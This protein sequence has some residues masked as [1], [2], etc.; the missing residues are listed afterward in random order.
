MKA[1]KEEQKKFTYLVFRDPVSPP[2]PSLLRPSRHV[3]SSKTESHKPCRA[4][5]PSHKQSNRLIGPGRLHSPVL[6]P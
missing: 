6:T 1:S 4:V 5:P 2:Q 3:S